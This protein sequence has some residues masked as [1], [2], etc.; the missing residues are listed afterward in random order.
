[1]ARRFE[2]TMPLQVVP[3]DLELTELAA[4]FKANGKLA[5]ADAFAAALAK[6]KK[7]ELFTADLE[8]KQVEREIK[9]EWVR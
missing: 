3:V 5:L 2:Q 1:M 8:F 9:I 4:D 7:A 6:Q